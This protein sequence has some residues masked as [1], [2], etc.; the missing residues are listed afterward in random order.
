MQECFGCCT[1]RSDLPTQIDNQ[2]ESTVMSKGS[3]LDTI[4]ED[5]LLQNDELCRCCND[6]FDGVR[7]VLK[8][9]DKNHIFGIRHLH[10]VLDGDNEKPDIFETV[11]LFGA[12]IYY[13]RYLEL[14][15]P[16][17]DVGGYSSNDKINLFIVSYVIAM[18]VLDDQ[19]I[20]MFDFAKYVAPSAP[21]RTFDFLVEIEGVFISESGIAWDTHISQAEYETYKTFSKQRVLDEIYLV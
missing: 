12:W 5:D 13:W 10:H 8:M 6:V 19:C 17:V 21:E 16:R 3:G 2:F 1:F 18:K 20:S 4:F 7:T 14:C 15:V 11:F 9:H